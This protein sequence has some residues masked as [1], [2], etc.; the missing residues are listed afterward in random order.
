MRGD[1]RRVGSARAEDAHGTP[2]QS[3]ISSSKLG[4]KDE[5]RLPETS[6]CS[7]TGVAACQGLQF[8]L[9]NSRSKAYGR[10]R[11]LLEDSA[12]PELQAQTSSSSFFVTLQPR[13][14]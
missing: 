10:F 5:C 4:Y 13:V 1:R 3:H 6:P 7:S 2:T 14:E 12:R 8:P 11:I 9:E